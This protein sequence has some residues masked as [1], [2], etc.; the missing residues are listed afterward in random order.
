MLEPGGDPQDHFE[1]LALLEYAVFVRTQDGSFPQAGPAPEWLKG[2]LS[3]L[4]A[5]F[6]SELLVETFP[7]LDVFLPDAEDLWNGSRMSRL[8]SDIWTQTDCSGKERRLRATAISAPS[9]NLLL[10]EPAEGLFT[11]TQGF[12]QHAHDATLAYDK[13]AKLSRALANANEQLEIRNQDVE[14]ATQAKS[15]F[16]ARMSHEIRTPMNA[17]LGMADLLWDTPLSPEQREYVR[18]FRRA[19]DNLLSVINDILDLSKVES[20]QM[21]LERVDFDLAEVLEKACEIIAVRAHAKGLELSC[22]VL[23]DV[24]AKLSGDPGRLRQVILNL[25]GNS[26]KFTERGELAVRVERDPDSAE[27]G[28]LF[29]AVSDTGIGIPSDKLTTVFESFSQVDTSTT[30]KYGGTGLGLAICKKFVELMGGRIWVESRLGEGSTFYFTAL[31]PALDSRSVAMP[32]FAGVRALVIDDNANHRIAVREILASW[33]AMAG[34]AADERSALAEIDV[35]ARSGQ[36][37]SVVL[38]D[39]R[40]PD[41]DSF[42]LADRI[43]RQPAAPSQIFVMLT[44]DRPAEAARC[45]E[46][47]LRPLLKPVRR[48]DLAE[49]LKEKGVGQPEPPAAATAVAPEVGPIRILLADDSD[50]NRFLIRAYL[51]NSGCLLDEARDG[52]EAVERFRSGRYQ[53]VLTDVEMPVLDGYSATRQMRAWENEQNLRPTPILALTAHALTE[54]TQKSLDA[55]CDAHLTKPIQKAVLFEAIRRYALSEAADSI[56]VL[57]DSALE[58]IIPVYL[59]NRRAEVVSLRAALARLDFPAVRITGHKLKGSGG[60]YGFPRLTELGAELEKAAM[61]NDP[62]SI[63]H[64]IEELHSYLQRIEVQYQ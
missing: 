2:F 19:G 13:I 34:D 63:R 47:G 48:P 27:P 59:E 9:H 30:R 28:A 21:E 55:G 49:A 35:A 64:S 31:F 17:I 62:E 56:H 38:L 52:R 33:G 45:R 46:L 6:T 53:L 36:A 12:V 24:P 10:I 54:A 61:A 18:I 15:E 25:L 42:Q 29:F 39:G 37:Y 51:R 3:T 4:Q 16:L 11:E 60:G 20:G 14:R 43:R 50:D 8:H 44:T 23:P 57:V 22:R 58:D 1:L 5:E 40:M 41:T 32:E 26:L 7:Y